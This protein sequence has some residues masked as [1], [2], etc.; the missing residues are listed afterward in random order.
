MFRTVLLPSYIIYWKTT[1]KLNRDK[2]STRNLLL[3]TMKTYRFSFKHCCFCSFVSITFETCF[4][5]NVL[6]Y[7][8][9][10][11]AYS[12]QIHVE[13]LIT[14]FLLVCTIGFRWHLHCS[15]ALRRVSHLSKKTKKQD[16][17]SSYYFDR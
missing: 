12:D 10:R 16:E 11:I 17:K 2:Y 13:S 7:V 4:N 1:L 14:L 5:P 6:D 8:Q 9:Y 15:S 3:I